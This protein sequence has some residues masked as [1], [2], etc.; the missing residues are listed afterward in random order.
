MPPSFPPTLSPSSF[1]SPDLCCICFT[2]SMVPEMVPLEAVPVAPLEGVPP[3]LSLG[4]RAQQHKFS[5]MLCG[6]RT[7]RW[8]W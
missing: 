4:G 1:A 7:C 8:H 3:A 5:T 6:Q 2:G